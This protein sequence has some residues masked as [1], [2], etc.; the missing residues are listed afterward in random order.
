MSTPS[1]LEAVF[2]LLGTRSRQ[3]KLAAGSLGT[4]SNFKTTRQ[5]C[6]ISASH[7][8]SDDCA[9][10]V[11]VN[12]RTCEVSHLN[13]SDSSHFRYALRQIRRWGNEKDAKN[14]L[15]RRGGTLRLRAGK[16]ET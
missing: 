5:Q 16:P 8:L 1:E 13:V 6:G 11:K 15:C 10:D 2:H 14:L 7:F 3:I 4:D 12:I 9:H